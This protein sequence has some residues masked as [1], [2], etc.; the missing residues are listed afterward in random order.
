MISENQRLYE[1]LDIARKFKEG[2]T[3]YAFLCFTVI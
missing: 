1:L 2:F 3:H